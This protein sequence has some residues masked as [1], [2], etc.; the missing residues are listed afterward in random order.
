MPKDLGE[1][2]L[3]A[4][5]TLVG[6]R[7]DFIQRGIFLVAQKLA[8]EWVVGGEAEGQLQWDRRAKLGGDRN[9]VVGTAICDEGSPSYLRRPTSLKILK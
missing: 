3:N 6:S 8:N 4:F 1:V 2:S 7:V 5:A 9:H